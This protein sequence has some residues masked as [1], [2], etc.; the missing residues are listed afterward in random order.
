LQANYAM[1]KRALWS[2]GDA[3]GVARDESTLPLSMF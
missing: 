1:M 3:Q 2:L